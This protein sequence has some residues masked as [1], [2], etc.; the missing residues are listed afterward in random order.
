[1]EAKSITSEIF[2]PRVNIDAMLPIIHLHGESYKP[3]KKAIIYSTLAHRV[4]KSMIK[5]A[6]KNADLRI[7]V[8]ICLP[9]GYGKKEFKQCIKKNTPAEPERLKTYCEPTSL[10]PEQLVGKTVRITQAGKTTYRKIH[11][12]L[13]S[14]FVVID[15]AI[16]LLTDKK[17]EE[18]RKYIRIALDPIGENTVMKRPVDI[19]PEQG[20]EYNP[21]CSMAVF[22]QD[23][24]LRGQTQL[25][26]ELLS[27]GLLRRFLV[28]YPHIS[29]EERFEGFE[30]SRTLV[31]DSVTERLWQEAIKN[32]VSI[33]TNQ[34]VDWNFSIVQDM[35]FDKTKDLMKIGVDRGGQCSEFAKMA[36]YDLLNH[37][38]R[39]SCIQAGIN[40]RKKVVNEDVERAFADLSEMWLLHL[41]FVAEMISESKRWEDAE[42]LKHLSVLVEA[43]CFDEASSTMSIGDFKKKIGDTHGNI[44]RKLKERGLIDG[45]QTGEHSS[46]VW[47]TKRG[48]EMAKEY[49]LM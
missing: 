27:E 9:S 23:V 42:L 36:M 2:S 48:I 8:M 38:A 20:L 21:D 18:S 44:Y 40:G 39:M 45:K 29:E 37:L 43:G 49:D 5:V 32:I 4:R 1:M 7:S 35:L 46:K 24:G 41:N 34:S 19:P 16:L 30:K 26:Y 17:H 3:L 10:H 12:F 31:D 25:P 15:E 6:D 28:L 14:T 33:A 47:L 11:G 13:N 22:L